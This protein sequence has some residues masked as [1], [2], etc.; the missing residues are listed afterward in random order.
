MASS[1]LEFHMDGWDQVVKEVVTTKGIPM[2]QAVADACNIPAT[3][4]VAPPEGKQHYM[5]SV[6][7]GGRLRLAD[8]HVTVITATRY[9]MRRNAKYSD[10]VRNF[11]RAG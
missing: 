10:L 9:A 11:H 2:M 3:E 6:E 7:G 8:Y 5:V 4:E 1:S